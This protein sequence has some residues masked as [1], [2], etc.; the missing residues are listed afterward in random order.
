M[1]GKYGDERDDVVNRQVQETVNALEGQLISFASELVR[2]KS[3]TGREANLVERIRQEMAKLD[4]DD[5][6]VDKVG[7][8]VGVIGDGPVKLLY[9]SHMD[10]VAVNDAGEWA[11]GPYSG[12]IAD[13][14]LYGRGSSDMKGSLAATVYAG[15]IMKKLGLAAGKTIYICCS[16][17][18]EDFDG[19]GLYR[20]IVDNG[21]KPDYVV[22]CE[23][24]H[25][26]IAM[27]HLGRAI[28]K[29]NVRGVSAHGAAPEKGDN[30]VYKAAAIIG[31][32][33]E[34]GKKYMAMPPERP[35]IALTR[36]ESVSASLNAVPGSCTLYVDRRICLHETEEAVG[37]EMTGLIGDADADW[38]IYDA[39]GQS[40]TGEEIVLHSYLPGWELGAEH[41][42]ARG[43]F[44]VYREVFGAE[45]KP[46]KWDFSTNGVASAKLGIP[47]IG[48][49]AGV[50]KTAHMA[51]EYCPL[52]D[53]ILA[54][55][56]FS[57]LPLKL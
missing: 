46:Y 41:P 40:Y 6:I 11:H 23:P 19:A 35:S 27:G 45:P 26:N 37:A 12:D 8:I 24:S 29:I 3:R 32:I 20:A 33:E 2:I 21:L 51:N 10:H 48:F 15:H 42:L 17:M 39:V 28:Y 52:E 1:G 47:T 9:D 4:Y 49:G 31:R 43:C 13:G 5:I 18:E 14:R 54:C 22:I 57:L 34:L 55:R 56:F 7:N 50:E 44:A 30:A 36:I 53:I 38:E 16:V 25:L